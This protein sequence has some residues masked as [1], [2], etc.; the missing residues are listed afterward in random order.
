MFDRPLVRREGTALRVAGEVEEAVEVQVVQ[1]NDTG[2][3]ELLDNE[4]P[5]FLASSRYPS[6]GPDLAFFSVLQVVGVFVGVLVQPHG[7]CPFALFLQG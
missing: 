7:P 6:Q 1:Q 2:R 5:P 3:L 4:L